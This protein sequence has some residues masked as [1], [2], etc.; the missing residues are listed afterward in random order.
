VEETLSGTIPDIVTPP[1]GGRATGSETAAGEPAP[2]ADTPGRKGPTTDGAASEAASVVA[3]IDLKF[4]QPKREG[5][6]RGGKQDPVTSGVRMGAF[7]QPSGRVVSPFGSEFY[8]PAFTGISYAFAGGKCT[9]TA[10]L[11]AVC[12]WGTNSGGDINVPTGAS[13]VITATNW[14]AIKADLEPGRTTPFKSKRDKYYSQPLVERH[15]KFHGTDD[16]G[17]TRSTGLGIVKTVLEAGAVSAPSAAADVASLVNG[18]R[19]RII[20]DNN[21]WYKG[22]GTDH[23][24][25]AGE[26]RA[27]ADGR[28]HYLALSKAVEATGKRLAEQESVHAQ[29]E[30]ER[31]GGATEYREGGRNVPAP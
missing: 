19:T 16:L 24:S 8:E 13:P 29:I 27:Y 22:A 10:T 4:S 17:W 30:R 6:S 21:A 14:P 28:P 9:I 18:A 1:G 5:V 12:P 31:L 20:T 23:D 11:N 25:F 7:S 2:T 15:E 3:N 26:I